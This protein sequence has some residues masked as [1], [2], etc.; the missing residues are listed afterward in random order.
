MQPTIMKSAMHNGL[1]MGVI[2]SLNF[3]LSVSG[4][5]FLHFLSIVIPVIILN[6]LYKMS[7]KYR[8]N[9]CDNTISY[10]K[11]LLHIIMIFFYAA[12]IST[13]VKFI[14]VSYIN[15]GFLD[16]MFQETM[17][18]ME[19]MKYPMTGDDIDNAEKMF[20]PLSFSFVYIW[21]NVIM[22]LITG[23]IMAAFIKKDKNIFEA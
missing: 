16:S 9:E 17:K 10:G 2:F 12:L 15:V 3:I 19:V 14:Y 21:T 1:I 6:L 4:V 13:V 23:L 7:V 11:A 5:P 20:K 18:T 22:G 8:V